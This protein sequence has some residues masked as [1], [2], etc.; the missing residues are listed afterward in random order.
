MFTDH[1]ETLCQLYGGTVIIEVGWN[2]SGK[3]INVINFICE[4]HLVDFS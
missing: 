2:D 1:D 3:L 4:G